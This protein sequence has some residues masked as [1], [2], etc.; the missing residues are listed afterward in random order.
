MLHFKDMEKMCYYQKRIKVLGM[1]STF[2]RYKDNIRVSRHFGL[3]LYKAAM[4]VMLLTS[5]A[6]CLCLFNYTIFL[7]EPLLFHTLTLK[8]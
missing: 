6:N 1:I 2:T 3:I 4:H 5:H 8:I 7:I